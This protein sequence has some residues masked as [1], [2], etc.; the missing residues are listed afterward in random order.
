MRPRQMP[1]SAGHAVEFARPPRRRSGRHRLMAYSLQTP[2]F[3]IAKTHAQPRTTAADC[4]AVAR[5]SD[6]A[7]E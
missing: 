6:A 1:A 2:I 7:D 3:S 4:R 5:A